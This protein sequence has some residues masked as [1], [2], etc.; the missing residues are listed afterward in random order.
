[1]KPV[2]RQKICLNCDGRIPIDAQECLYCGGKGIA[3][4]ELPDI[5][6]IQES[7]SSIYSP[8]YSKENSIHMKQEKQK[9]KPIQR[10]SHDNQLHAALGKLQHSQNAPS[11]DLAIEKEKSSFAPLFFLLLGSN[12]LI[13]GLLQLLFSTDGLLRLE[14][15][16]KYWFIYCLIGLPTIIIGLKKASPSQ[17]E[18]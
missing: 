2:D 14:W 5:Q 9:I 13:L 3:S 12:L 18:D 11:E 10:Q 16:S 1:M 8:P 15:T 17:K 6:S 4:K 7:L